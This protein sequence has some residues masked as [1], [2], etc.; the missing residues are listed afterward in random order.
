MDSLKSNSLVKTDVSGYVRDSSTGSIINMN[1][2]D[3]MRYTRE[4]NTALQQKMIN[5]KVNQLA[6]TVSEMKE[7]LKLLVNK[8]HGS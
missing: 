5:Q 4:K 1:E 7:I 2:E 3:Y 6:E 8:H